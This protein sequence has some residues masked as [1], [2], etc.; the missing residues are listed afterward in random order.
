M[1]YPPQFVGTRVGQLHTVVAVLIAG[2]ILSARAGAEI[3]TG[4]LVGMVTLL[5]IFPGFLILALLATRR[6]RAAIVAMIVPA[7]FVLL[8]L[9]QYEAYVRKFVMVH[10]YPI[11]AQLFVSIPAL[12]ERLFTQHEYGVAIVE[13]NV[14]RTLVLILGSI[15]VLSSMVY[16]IRR[17]PGE[18]LIYAI[19]V[20]AML[21]LAPP[22]G[23]YHLNLML[24]ALAL[25]YRSYF[26]DGRASLAQHD[27]AA[28]DQPLVPQRRFPWRTLIAALLI[29]AI[30]L[31]YGLSGARSGWP[32]QVYDW[33]HQGWGLFLLTPQ[34]YGL[35]L[36]FAIC[37]MQCRRPA[38]SGDH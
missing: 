24:V 34:L 37:V 22:A 38:T 32:R 20:C 15:A 16:A 36:I 26:G 6:W 35:I 12:A 13:S 14:L 7:A 11:A 8:T 10:G 33:I 29:T 18:P 27:R 1:L 30:P 3:K 31:E 21:L 25:C 4:L 17:R 9:D 2:S 23:A 19:F 5:K 28:I